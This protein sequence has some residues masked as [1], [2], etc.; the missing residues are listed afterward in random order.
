M[1]GNVLEA[2]KL[3]RSFDGLTALTEVS[4]AIAPGELVGI[5]GANGAGK[6]TFVNI[7][8]GYVK[9]E[10]G[11]VYLFGR[12]VTH[13]TAREVT[14]MGI[15]RSFQVAQ[16]F[17]ELTVLENVLV[18]LGATLTRSFWRPL[19]R[20]KLLSQALE[21]LGRFGIAEYREYKAALLPQGVRK[22]LDIAMAMSSAPR[23][24]LL[25]EPTSG[26][27]AEEKFPLMDTLLAALT[28]TGAA[29]LFVEHDMEIVA[30]YAHRVVAFHEG[31]V[32]ANGA[33]AEVL[34][35]E[36][37]RTYVTGAISAAA[38]AQARAGD[39]RA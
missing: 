2:V 24:V 26:V 9:P 22:L 15:S 17:P 38:P 25:D 36:R 20:P 14:R 35:D 30:R 1:A 39:V 27:S 34:A 19:H 7:V 23:L 37:V 28:P 6:T 29:V 13:R 31:R 11:R 3:S 12:D 18:A 10:A 21:L 4:V 5:I 33:P 32:I 8:T 16:I